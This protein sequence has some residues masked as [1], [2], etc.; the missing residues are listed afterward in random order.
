MAILREMYIAISYLPHSRIISLGNDTS[1]RATEQ[2]GRRSQ[3]CPR[4][5]PFDAFVA[6]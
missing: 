3:I 4:P 1:A 6:T 5:Y 2:C